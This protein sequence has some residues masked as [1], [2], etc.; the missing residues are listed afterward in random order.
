MN[1]KHIGS[2]FNDYPEEKTKKELTEKEILRNL[3][4]ISEK[5][6]SEWDNEEDEIYNNLFNFELS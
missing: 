6:F 3:M 4:K 5:S 2:T 1:N